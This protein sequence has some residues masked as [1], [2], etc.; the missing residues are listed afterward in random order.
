MGGT[1]WDWDGWEWKEIRVKGRG[2]EKRKGRIQGMVVASLRL[3]G[4]WTC[5][6][7]CLKLTERR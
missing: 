1:G 4:R 5:R 6:P 3:Y 2:R 7:K